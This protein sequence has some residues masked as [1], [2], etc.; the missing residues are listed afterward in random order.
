VDIRNASG[1]PA[2]A[3]TVARRLAAAGVTVGTTTTGQAL[4]SA[5]LY[6][7]GKADAAALVARA[8]G[9]AGATAAGADH[10][11][12][13]I[14]SGDAAAVLTALRSAAGRAELACAAG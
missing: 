2:V 11:T 9:R 13:V 6:P 8:M 14:G 7:A 3:A 12:I 4:A 10:V 1:D 5:V